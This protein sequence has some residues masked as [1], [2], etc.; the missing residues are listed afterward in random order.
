MVASINLSRRAMI[1]GAVALGA[2]SATAARPAS[3]PRPFPP[4]FL[5]GAATAGHQVEGGN[6]NADNWLLETVSPTIYAQPSGDACDHYHRFRQ[7]IT[8]LKQLGLNAFRFSIEWSRIEPEQGMVSEAE[9]N[10]YRR[11]L[12]VCHD[13]GVAPVVTLNHYTTPRWFAALGCWEDDG[14]PARFAAYCEWVV[15]RLGPL[16]G[17]VSTFNEPNIRRLIRLNRHLTGAWN[18]SETAMIAAARAH[19]GSPRF[20]TEAFCDLDR[21][22]ANM[23]RAHRQAVARIKAVQPALAVGLNLA[24]TGEQ[25]MPGGEAALRQRREILYRPWLDMARDDD[26]IGVQ[27]YTRARIGPNGKL[28]PEPGV[29]LTDAGYEYWPWALEPTIRYAAAQTGKPVYVTENGVGTA[30]DRLRIRFI[31]EAVKGVAQCLADGIDVRSYIHWALLDNFEWDSG[32][33]P[34]FGLVAV[35][36][37]NFQRSIKTSGIYLGNIARNNGLSPLL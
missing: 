30:D 10:H 5:W 19:S 29:L 26:F 7:D 1:Q 8:L 2:T 33:K 23:L 36:R 11:V 15:R 3:A 6:I 34:K 21:M 12:E 20:I 35:D 28:P 14:S 16:L 17:I 31:H 9:C 18:P 24:M 4:H 22:E 32:F 37:N 25:A 13:L 27:T